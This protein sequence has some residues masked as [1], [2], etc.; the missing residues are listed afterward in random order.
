MSAAD[1]RLARIAELRREAAL[2]RLLGNERHRQDS[3]PRPRS[4]DR[5]LAAESAALFRQADL[6]DRLAGEIQA[7]IDREHLDGLRLALQLAAGRLQ[8]AHRVEDWQ[9]GQD[10][11][12]AAHLAMSE[13]ALDLHLF[14]RRD[15]L[16]DPGRRALAAAELLDLFPESTTWA[17][18]WTRLDRVLTSL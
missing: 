8:E 11:I 17:P 15:R 12:R 3:T 2:D 5:D 10:A 16:A 4:C 7:E 1:P 18:V 6:A 13:A 14:Q 9:T